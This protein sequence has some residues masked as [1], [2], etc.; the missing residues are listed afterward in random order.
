MS[1]MVIILDVHDVRD[2]IELEGLSKKDVSVR[3]WRQPRCPPHAKI[4]FLSSG[5][6]GLWSCGVWIM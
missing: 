3:T 2:V 6:S 5:L 1:V 4:L